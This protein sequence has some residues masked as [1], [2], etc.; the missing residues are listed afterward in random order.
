LLGSGYVIAEPRHL[1]WFTW[2]ARGL[3]AAAWSRRALA[4]VVRRSTGSVLPEVAAVPKAYRTV[5]TGYFRGQ[6]VEPAALPVD[7]AGTRFQARVWR[8]IRRINR[9]QVRTYAGVAAAVGSPG[10]AR[11]V[12]NASNANPLPVVVPCHRIVAAGMRLGGYGG[13]LERKKMLLALDGVPVR[14][15]VVRVDRR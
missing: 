15:G 14:E 5:L 2:N 3:V 4:A 6:A 12:G 8:A 7:L 10:A 13:G 1:F 9:G 11:A